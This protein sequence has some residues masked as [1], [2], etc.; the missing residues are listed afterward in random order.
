VF[1]TICRIRF[2]ESL[3]EIRLQ[4]ENHRKDSF[5]PDERIV[6]VQDVEDNYDYID[7]AGVKLIEIQKLVNQV[8]ISN[9]FIKIETANTEIADELEYIK[10]HYSLDNTSFDFEIVPGNY[11]KK[12]KK[13]S[14]TTC[15]KLWNHLYV[16]TAGEVNLCCL[17]DHRF[18]LGNVDNSEPKEIIHSDR[19]EQLRQYQ[20]QGYRIRSC[21]FCYDR[22][23][24]GFESSRQ[25]LHE[26]TNPVIDTVSLDLRVNNICNFK[27]RMCSEYFSSSILQETKDRFGSDSVLGHEQV[28]L[29][30]VDK[31]TRA[32]RVTKILPTV[33]TETQD[34]YFAGG[35]PLITFEHYQ[36]LDRL[37]ELNHTNLKILYNTNL[38]NLSFKG[39]NVIDYWKQFQNVTVGISIDASDKVAEYMRH[40]TVWNNIVKNLNTVK[41]QAPHVNLQIT[42]TVSFLTVENLIKLQQYWLQ[43]KTFTEEQLFVNILT[44]PNFYSVSVLPDEHKS[45]LN[46]IINKHIEF[47]SSDGLKTQWENV[48][49]YMN[50]NNH[51]YALPEFIKTTKGLD[52]YR[53]E[54]FVDTFSQFADLLLVD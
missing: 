25:S 40:G 21:K 45:I 34:I 48:K 30:T 32:N 47:V 28:S 14:D 18:P 52:Q 43:E 20:L 51:S 22:E 36:I 44:E 26:N 15:K 49:N 17:A 6:I 19:F 42:S 27:C 13:Y 37:I 10:Q 46:D 16:G 31:S 7:S 9:C 38:S 3:N 54:S 33:T 8:D 35:E 24:N 53:K 29:N 50:T 2:S 39:K 23:D 11:N 12:F 41:S 4:L 1:K 5:G